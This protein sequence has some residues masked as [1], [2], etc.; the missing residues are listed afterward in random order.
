LNPHDIEDAER[1]L[2]GVQ[3]PDD[4]REWLL[5]TNGSEK[6]SG[7]VF[8]MVYPLAE[9]V[10]VTQAAEADERLPRTGGHRVRRWR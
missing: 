3:F 2:G 10:A 9:V 4:Y 5:S 8:V 1:Q 6:W 7:E